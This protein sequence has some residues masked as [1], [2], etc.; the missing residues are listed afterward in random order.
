MGRSLRCSTSVTRRGRGSLPRTSGGGSRACRARRRRLRSP[1]DRSRRSPMSSS[2]HHSRA[3]VTFAFALVASVTPVDGG[4]D[5]AA[6]PQRLPLLEQLTRETQALQAEVRQSVLRVQLP[7]PR[8]LDAAAGREADDPLKKYKDL[9]PR[10]REQLERRARRAASAEAEP[11]V[12]AGA[13]E[14]G[15]ASRPVSDA[16]IRLGGNAAVIVIPPPQPQGARG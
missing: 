8:W 7:P 14:A 9:D 1:R 6:E 4:T 11:L 3:L 15:P 16:D 12:S 2:V 5:P 10:V 13:N